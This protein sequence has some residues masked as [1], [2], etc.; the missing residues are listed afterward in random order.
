VRKSQRQ[1]I[2]DRIEERL[3][4]LPT[5]EAYG[6]EVREL[7]K[8]LIRWEEIRDDPR[9]INIRESLDRKIKLVQA[10]LET[11]KRFRRKEL[12]RKQLVKELGRLG[13]ETP[14]EK[15]RRLKAECPYGYHLEGEYLLDPEVQALDQRNGHEGR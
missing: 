4:E 12:V 6:T 5:E 15:L 3:R 2:H 11:E 9:N 7:E 8:Q 1:K 13:V 10:A 14:A